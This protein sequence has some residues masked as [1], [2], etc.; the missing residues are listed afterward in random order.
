[1]LISVL[2]GC[3]INQPY[4]KSGESFR[5]LN[6]PAVLTD[7]SLVIKVVD[8]NVDSLLM[9][10]ADGTFIHTLSSTCRPCIK[11]ILVLDTLH[12]SYGLNVKNFVLDDWGKNQRLKKFIV[13]KTD[14]N[15]VF[16]LSNDL[17]NKE[18]SN[19]ERIKQF[20]KL[21]CASCDP[22]TYYSVGYV[23][24][25]KF[26]LLEQEEDFRDY[27]TTYLASLEPAKL[28]HLINVFEVK[29]RIR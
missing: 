26:M 8:L 29:E 19:E 28:N 24:K 14:F 2:S 21:I 11:K 20:E 18:F 12:S 23:M 16:I 13:A 22:K 27:F 7:D 4:S 17:Y 15:E 6:D 5:S 10:F 1:M 25:G 3:V 9:G